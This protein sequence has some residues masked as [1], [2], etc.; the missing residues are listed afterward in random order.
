MVDPRG[1]GAVHFNK[2]SFEPGFDDATYGGNGTKGIV[3]ENVNTELFAV[4]APIPD[5]CVIAAT[6]TW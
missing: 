6:D 3:D 4:Y 5:I 1:S 2:I